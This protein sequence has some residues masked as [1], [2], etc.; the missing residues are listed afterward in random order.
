MSRKGLIA[1][2]KDGNNL[3]YFPKEFNSGNKKLMGVLRQKSL[4]RIILFII[5]HEGCSHEQIAA[6]VK[7]S[8]STASWHLKK[9]E[10]E[11]MIA[12]VKGGRKTFYEV[13]ANKEEIAKLLI[14]YRK[15]FFDALVDRAIEMWEFG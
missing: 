1:C 14:T 15:S 13:S 10:E 6:H 4:M 9:L 12:P 2:E 5:T 7:L 8:P 11:G 3:R